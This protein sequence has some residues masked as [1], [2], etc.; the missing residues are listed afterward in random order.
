VAQDCPDLTTP[1]SSDGENAKSVV[2]IVI[3]VHNRLCPKIVVD[4]LAAQGKHS[5]VQAFSD[6]HHRS[7]VA[8]QGNPKHPTCEEPKVAR[9]ALAER[10]LRDGLG[11]HRLPPE[12]F[13]LS[14]LID[15]D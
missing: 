2:F 6:N 11:S 13:C 9:F 15:T 7:D 1:C 8:D 10:P 14:V 4:L 3:E 5:K 12:G